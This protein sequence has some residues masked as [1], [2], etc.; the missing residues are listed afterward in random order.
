LSDRE[1]AQR[2][3]FKALAIEWAQ[4]DP[5]VVLE[6]IAFYE[7]EAK[8]ISSYM[9]NMSDFCWELANVVQEPGPW[10]DECLSQGL[11]SDL[12]GPACMNDGIEPAGGRFPHHMH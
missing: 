4:D 5:K 10:L 3:R 11:K 2:E 9:R 8:K 6:K 12:V 7:E 1:A